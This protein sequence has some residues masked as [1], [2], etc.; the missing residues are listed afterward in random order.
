M[1]TER[2]GRAG[3]SVAGE[4]AGALLAQRTQVD[5]GPAGM[6]GMPLGAGDLSRGVLLRRQDL[7]ARRMTPEGFGSTCSYPRRRY[8][9]QPE[10]CW[11]RRGLGSGGGCGCCGVQSG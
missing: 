4:F 11:L 8:R 10:S 6:G 3:R 1:V 2:V 7:R 9:P 5:G